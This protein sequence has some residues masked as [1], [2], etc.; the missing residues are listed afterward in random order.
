MSHNSQ[1]IY[2]GFDFSSEI[3]KPVNL[4]MPVEYGMYFSVWFSVYFGSKF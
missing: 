1:D 4:P 3:E 2:I